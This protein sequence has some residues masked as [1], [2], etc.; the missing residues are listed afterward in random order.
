MLPAGR[1]EIKRLQQELGV[2]NNL[3]Q[4]GLARFMYDD[5]MIRFDTGFSSGNVLKSSIDLIK[6]SAK[7]MRTW[8][9][10]QHGRAKKHGERIVHKEL[11]VNMKKTIPGFRRSM[12]YVVVFGCQI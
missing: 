11:N 12:F 4:F 7:K 1:E 6:P 3:S 5:E 9:Q 2:K 10:V 8:F